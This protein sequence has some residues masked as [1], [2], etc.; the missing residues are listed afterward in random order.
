MCAVLCLAFA[1][2][3]KDRNS[4]KDQTGTITIKFVNKVKDQPVGLGSTIHTNAFN[5][6][7]T[8]TKLKYYVTNVGAGFT[9]RS[10]VTV[11]KEKDSYHLIDESKPTLNSFTFDAPIN[12]YSY[13]EF[14]LGVDSTRNVS[15]AQTNALDPLNDM[16]WTWNSGYIMAKLEGTSAVSNAVNNQFEYHIGGFSGNNSVLKNIRVPISGA[17]VI[18]IR[19][20]KNSIVEIEADFDK[21][22]TQPNNLKIA[23][24]PIC[25]V[26]GTLAKKYAD[27]YADMF[28][29]KW[30]TNN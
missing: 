27:N 17:Y 30:V 28:V 20:G 3:K 2:C 14:V 24:N 5:E 18:D 4:T 6:P 13:V 26:P 15:G 11:A 12:R 25:I 1:A 10:A 21:W 7:Y 23:D 22:F 19:D 16:F 9:D 29:M 8:I